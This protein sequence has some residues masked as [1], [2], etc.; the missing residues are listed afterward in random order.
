MF[1]IDV[2]QFASILFRSV[3]IRYFIAHLWVA[4]LPRNILVNCSGC[5][6]ALDLRHRQC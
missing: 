6:S 1:R 4:F 5:C 2:L 3:K